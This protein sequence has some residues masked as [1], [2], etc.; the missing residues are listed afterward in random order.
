MSPDLQKL[1]D[2]LHTQLGYS[3]QSGGY[4]K[5]GDWYGKNV[6]FDSDYSAQPWCDMFLSWAAHQL[7]YEKWFGQFAYAPFH[8]E[9]FADRGAWGTTPE[10][11][12]VVFFDWGGSNVIENIDHVGIVTSVDGDTIH[13]IEGNIDGQY[14]R[15]KVRD[16]TY[17][18]GYGYPEKVK[19]QLE[20]H[21]QA[22]KT[23]TGAAT[24]AMKPAAAEFALP[25]ATVGVPAGG[26][27]PGQ[28]APGAGAL[29]IPVLIAVMVMIAYFKV[30]QASARLALAAPRTRRTRTTGGRTATISDDHLRP[31]RP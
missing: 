27:V 14:A 30:K 16:Q 21:S 29:V 20:A 19:A 15:E 25:A 10:P 18:V 9:W 26:P 1:I 7:G 24:P 22:S 3:E 8:A 31:P 12:A 17:V 4:T 5:F 6:E 23:S 2:L 13:T 28:A 11:G